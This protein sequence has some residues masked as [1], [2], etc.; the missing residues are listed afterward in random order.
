MITGSHRTQMNR[1]ST[2]G[3]YRKFS[4]RAR[5]R[6]KEQ[7]P[8]RRLNEAYRLC[9][10]VLCG[11]VGQQW[12]SVGIGELA[13]AVLEGALGIRPSWRSP[14]IPP[15]AHRP[16]AWVTSVQTTIRDN[17]IK[18]LLSTALPTRARPRF[19]NHQ[20]SHQSLSVPP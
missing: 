9:W 1:N 15:Y 7:R 20:S 11:G 4:C 12:L 18:A 2:L 3:E 6:G 16:Q 17:W 5:S 10:R 14:L 13:A 19:F 8:H